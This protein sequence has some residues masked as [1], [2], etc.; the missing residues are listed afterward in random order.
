MLAGKSKLSLG[1]T[2]SPVILSPGLLE[3]G[4]GLLQGPL[5]LPV[6]LSTLFMDLLLRLHPVSL[7]AMALIVEPRELAGYQS[8]LCMGLQ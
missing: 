8:R 3:L 2:L 5:V 1:P 4:F 7:I 6:S